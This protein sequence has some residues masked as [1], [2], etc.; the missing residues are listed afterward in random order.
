MEGRYRLIELIVS[1]LVICYR[2]CLDMHSMAP[3][4]PLG[5]M[6]LI[7][8]YGELTQLLCMLSG[9]HLGYI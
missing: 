7:K 1:G 9:L 2:F 4:T 6:E 5:V 8:R 3:C